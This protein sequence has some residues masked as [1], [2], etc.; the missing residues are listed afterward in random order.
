MKQDSRFIR[1]I[2]SSPG[3]LSFWQLKFNNKNKKQN[4]L[5]DQKGFTLVEIIIAISLMLVGVFAVLGM[6][7]VALQ[8]NSIA[9]QLSVATSLASMALEDISSTSWTS[10]GTGLTNG[11]TTLQYGNETQYGTYSYQS[12]GLYT[13]R[14]TPTLNSPIAG[15]AR[16]DVT[17]IYS[18]K[19]NQK[20]VTITGFKRLV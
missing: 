16:L 2:E 11:A 20:S 8:S 13:I 14:C 5:K 12:V 19:G 15:I 1:D 18:Y 9:N 3:L 6:Q 17:A 10:N 7:T 4:C